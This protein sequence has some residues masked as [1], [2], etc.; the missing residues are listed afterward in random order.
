MADVHTPTLRG[1]VLALELRTLRDRA[2]L[3]QAEAARRLNWN[4]SKL[5]RIEEPRTGVSDEDVKAL[6]QLYGLDPDRHDAIIQLNRDSWQRGWWTA[7]GSAFTSNGNFPMLEGQA[8]DLCYYENALV[9]GLFQ[10]PDYA[11]AVIT[12]L[13]PGLTP[14]QIDERVEARKGRQG[15]LSRANP[16][17]IHA[18]IDESVVRHVIGG[19]DVMRAQISELWRTAQ[20]PNITVQLVPFSAGANSGLAGPFT[21]FGHPSRPG[22]DVGHAEGLLGEWYAESADELTKIRL[23]FACV[24]GAAMSPERTSEFLVSL[25]QE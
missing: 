13:R 18:V 2:D 22:L 23:A 4:K 15:I 21:L 19:A 20:E 9:P 16:P 11:R 8:E 24:S 7:Y 17:T 10:T 3:T 14:A 6:L 1:R 5:S 12:H 25:T